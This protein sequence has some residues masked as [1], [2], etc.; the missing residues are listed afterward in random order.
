MMISLLLTSGCLNLPAKIKIVFIVAKHVNASVEMELVFDDA[1][2]SL[3]LYLK[4]TLLYKLKFLELL[5][6]AW[7]V[8][9]LGA[10]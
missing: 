7:L 8:I 5:L 2:I 1:F 3:I 4:L 6:R 9:M 10:D